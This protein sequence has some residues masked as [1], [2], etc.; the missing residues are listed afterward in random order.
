LFGTLRE[1][2]GGEDEDEGEEEEG[3]HCESVA[4]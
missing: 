4:G 2:E 3:T 1:E